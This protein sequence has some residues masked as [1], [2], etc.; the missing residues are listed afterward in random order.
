ML[1]GP[2][3]VLVGLLWLWLVNTQ[4]PDVAAEGEP[5]PRAMPFLLGV[6]LAILGVVIAVAPRQ[7]EPRQAQQHRDWR[8]ALTTV[9]LLLVYAYA[10]DTLGFISST[11]LLMLAAMAGVLSMRR[12][13][14]MLVFSMAFAAGTWLVFNTVLGI[15]LPRDPWLQ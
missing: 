7:E 14:F 1:L 8:A 10:L 13:V 5:G 11:T 6:L 12:W 15:P 2:L 9:A 4:I 3:L